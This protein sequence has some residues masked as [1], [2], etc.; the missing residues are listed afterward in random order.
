MGNTHFLDGDRG[1]LLDL[2]HGSG[3]GRRRSSR[4]PDI[5]CS[6]GGRRGLGLVASDQQGRSGQ[7]NRRGAHKIA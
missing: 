1:R 6:G 3:R 4:C 2:R 5:L 7:G